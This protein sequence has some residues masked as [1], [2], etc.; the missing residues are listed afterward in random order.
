MIT[1]IYALMCYLWTLFGIGAVFAVSLVFAGHEPLLQRLSRYKP[2][3]RRHLLWLVASAPVIIGFTFAAEVVFLPEFAQYLGWSADHC[4]LHRGNHGHLC[5]HHPGSFH[6]ASVFGLF[7]IV[8]GLFITWR[9]A[10]VISETYIYNRNANNLM[11]FIEPGN[12]GFSRL[13]CDAFY[14]FTVGFFRPLPVIS[15]GLEQQLSARKL[16]LVILHEKVH[17]KKRDPLKIWLFT[18]LTQIFPQFIRLKL[19]AAYSLAVEQAA[20]AEVA[21]MVP[22]RALVAATL[23][24]VS[25]LVSQENKYLP[26]EICHFGASPL[27]QRVR[28][29]LSD[30]DGRSFRCSIATF[31]V[32]VL[33]GSAF[34]SNF[35]HDI[36]ESFIFH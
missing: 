3:T 8:L 17:A 13:G 7:G 25:R 14:A 15:R 33:I 30:N 16:N 6:L 18:V 21:N 27:E 31:C 9:L 1:G 12:R 11:D 26:A 32:S 36:V 34:L 20:D 4:H 35:L 28:Y 5:S 29:L 2:S 24:E 19:N 23:V 22:D 10:R